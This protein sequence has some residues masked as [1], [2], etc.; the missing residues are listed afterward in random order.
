M[1]FA[2]IAFIILSLSCLLQVINL[3][4]RKT[5]MDAFSQIPL[6]AAGFFLFADL[7]YRSII[8]QFVAVTNMF[9]SL[10]LFSGLISLLC[11]F[12]WLRNREKFVRMVSFGASFV[13]FCLLAI[14]SSPLLSK[15]I[16]PPIP[17]LQSFWL[18]LHISLA[19][20]GEAFFV[21]GFITAILYLAAKN[22]EQKQGL[23]RI[24]YTSI[25]IGY[26]IYT[27]GAL[28]FGAIWAYFS[29]GSFWSWDPK[30]TWALVTWLVYTLF[31]HSRFVK[32]WRGTFSA[33]LS[34]AGFAITLF[35]LFGVSFL[36]S[37]LHG[38]R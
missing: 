6:A 3:F 21:I 1:N 20:I 4:L 16:L 11:F 38:Y 18:V 28:I 8:I 9:E 29:W 7:V 37:S 31:L 19:F 10:I 25:A 33:V 5:P 13:A 14:A 27:A 35:T 15:E 32:K 34:I 17:A 22:D 12:Y 23:D 2:E 24:M 36:L 26:P 30:E